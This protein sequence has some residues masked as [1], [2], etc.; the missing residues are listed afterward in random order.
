[1]LVLHN[2]H[3]VSNSLYIMGLHVFIIPFLNSDFN[4]T[5][6]SSV[7]SRVASL[8]QEAEYSYLY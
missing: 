4:S 1:M 5:R 3:Q 2:N 6:N 8:L 7:T